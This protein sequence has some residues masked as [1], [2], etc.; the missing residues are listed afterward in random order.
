MFSSKPRRIYC[1]FTA[2]SVIAAN[3]GVIQCLRGV[4]GAT[5]HHVRR[6]PA[7]LRSVP[8]LFL[9]VLWLRASVLMPR[10]R[11]L[12]VFS[13][14]RP[15]YSSLGLSCSPPPTTQTHTHTQPL[16]PIT[17]T[18]ISMVITFVPGWTDGRSSMQTHAYDT[19]TLIQAAPPTTPP[20]TPHP[21][22]PNGKEWWR[23]FVETSVW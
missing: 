15:H 10:S 7:C 2:K 18:H 21:P 11:L 6:Q 23:V 19:Q 20:T 14:I 16:G 17:L 4:R 22:C 3:W 8:R 9:D 5:Y 13:T 12:D 1:T